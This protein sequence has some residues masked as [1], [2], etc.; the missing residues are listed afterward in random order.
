M[1]KYTKYLSYVLRHKW[2]VMIEC[3][4]RGLFLRGIMHDMSKFRPS[5]FIPYARYFNGDYPTYES[6][7]KFLPMSYKNILTK[8]RVEIEFNYAWLQHIHRNKH[9]W[10]YWVLR[11]DDGKVIAMKIP[12]KYIDEMISDWNG[13]GKAITGKDNTLEWYRENKDNMI[14]HG[15]TRHQIEITI[16]YVE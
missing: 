9:H 10:Q 1:R 8:E 16:H 4:S 13:A 6:I 7:P 14:L 15:K 2:Y 5:E 3:F 11:E 12:G